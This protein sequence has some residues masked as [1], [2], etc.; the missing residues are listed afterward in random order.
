VIDPSSMRLKAAV[1][2]EALPV[3]RVGAPVTFR[4][5]GYPDQTFAGAID[6]IAPAADE[7]TRQIPVWVKIPNPGGKLVAGLFA[8]GRIADQAR[9]GLVVPLAAVNLI[10][11][12]PSVKRVVDDRVED[13]SVGV[14]IRDEIGRT[15]EITRGLGEGDLLLRGAASSIAAGTAVLLKERPMSA[16]DDNHADL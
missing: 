14:G 10:T 13:V 8:E 15:I 5:R 16:K 11:T 3:V 2:S 6:R 12:P 4:V 7:I 1:P 9:E